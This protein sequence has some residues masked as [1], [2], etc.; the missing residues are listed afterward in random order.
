MSLRAPDRLLLA[1]ARRGGVWLGVT[2]VTSLLLTGATLALPAVMG[3]TLDAVLGHGDVARWLAL[4]GVLIFVMVAVDAVDDLVG[5]AAE[6]RSTAWLRHTLLRHV[7]ALGTRAT[8]RFPPGDLVSRLVGN[9]ARTGNAASGLVWIVMG[10]VPPLGAIVAL[11]LIDYWL[12]LTFLAGMPVLV[13]L[14]RAFLRDISDASEGYFRVQGTIAARLVDA[15]GGIRT[16]T[17][18]GT[19]DRE[20]RRVLAPSPSCTGTDWACGTPSRASRHAETWS[21]RCWWSPSWPWPVWGSPK[22][23]SRPERCSRRASTWS[24]RPESAA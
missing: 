17:A 12:C 9:S 22:G 7:L 2:V 5:Q 8:R 15:L 18:A 24:W 21:S 20:A 3:R 10:V 23:A 1:S 11:A 13:L 14:V 19:I 6:A 16:I 4:S